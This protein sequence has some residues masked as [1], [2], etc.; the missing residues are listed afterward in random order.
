MI[1]SASRRTDIPAFYSRWFF[2]R[3]KAGEVMVRNPMNPKQVSRISL[4]PGL[5]DAIVFWTRNPRP[6]LDHLDLLDRYPYYFLFT[7]TSY[8]EDLEPGLPPGDDITATF[9]ELSRRIGRERVVWRYDPILL[10]DRIDENHHLRHFTAMAAKLA[11]YTK[12]C[13]IS[14]LD[15]YNKCKRNLKGINIM[16][17]EHHQ[18]QQ[19]RIG[20]MLAPVAK[21]KGIELTTCAE[22]IDFS[23]LGIGHGKCIDDRLIERIS[24][25]SLETREDKHQRKTCRCVESIDIG[26]YNTCNHLCLYCYANTGTEAVRRNIAL[27]DPSSPLMMGR[28]SGDEKISLR[29]IKSFKKIP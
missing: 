8:G 11:P 14:F 21:E 27:H 26:A 22:E 6:M 5:V 29:K 7:I 3:I 13:I 24:G 18:T 16:D 1:I 4:D 2:N 25:N 9:M 12:R 10:T 19:R 28:L 17:L 15:M 23:D 20:E